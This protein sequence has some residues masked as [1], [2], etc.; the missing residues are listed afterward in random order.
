[1]GSGG[2]VVMDEATVWLM[3]QI[4]SLNLSPRNHAENAYLA[5]KEQ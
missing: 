5:V 2:L 4:P 1:M 3:S